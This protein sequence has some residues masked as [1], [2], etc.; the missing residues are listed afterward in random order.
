MPSRPKVLHDQADYRRCGPPEAE[1]CGNIACARGSRDD[2][3]VGTRPTGGEA[4]HGRIRDLGPGADDAPKNLSTARPVLLPAL[5]SLLR[6]PHQCQLCGVD[7]E[8]RSG[9]QRLSLWAGGRC[10]LLGLL[11]VGGSLQ[12]HPG[13]GWCA[14]LDCADHDLLGIAVCGDGLGDRAN[15]LFYRPRA[16]GGGRG[17]PVPR[18][19]AVFSPLVP[20]EPSWPGDRLVPYRTAARDGCTA[21]NGCLSAR[22]SRPR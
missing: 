20:A 10:I 9:P 16:V 15:Q 17:G 4:D 8:P 3:V 11:P 1:P 5:H 18:P 6:R 14:R 13:T 19:V 22:V 12:H 7:D 21:G 2:I